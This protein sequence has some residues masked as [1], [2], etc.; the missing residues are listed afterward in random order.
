MRNA[1]VVGIDH[2]EWS[3]LAACINDANSITKELETDYNGKKN[4]EVT[5]LTSDKI[6]ITK[7]QLFRSV[8]ELF[9]KPAEVAFLFFSGHGGDSDLGGY[10]VTEDAEK[11]DMGV[12][13][14][15]IVELANLAT[16]IQEIIIV[17]DACYSGHA[18]NTDPLQNNIASLRMGVSILASS[19]RTQ[20]SIEKN[21]N[22][23]FT[24][25]VLEALRGGGADVLGDITVAGVYNYVDKALGPLQQRPVFKSHI[26]ELNTIKRQ[27]PQ[28]SEKKLKK[29]LKIFPDVDIEYKLKPAHEP[30]AKPK[31]AKKEAIFSF[32]QTCRGVNLIEPV[33]EEHMYYAAINKKSCRLT[34]LGKL[35]WKM[36][37]HGNLN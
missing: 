25:L 30:Q 8:R 12:A 19:K 11:H 37:Q 21:G 29:L 23:L 2:Y 5:K 9:S 17:I 14:N 10:L 22:G 4:F 3:P 13:L 7:P 36:I 33:G 18:G 35:Y 27:K 31:N 32:L 34:P 28:I 20:Y 1:L 16:H 24:A 6:R 15:E 26:S